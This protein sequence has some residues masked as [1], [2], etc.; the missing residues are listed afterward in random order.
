MG[1]VL[2]PR[3]NSVDIATRPELNDEA[4]VN[5]ILGEDEY[6]LKE[7][8]TLSGFMLDIGAHVGSVGLA[9]AV[10]HPALTVVMVEPVPDN[11]RLIRESIS[12]NHLDGRVHL[13]EAAAGAAGQRTAVCR[14]GYH[15]FQ[16]FEDPRYVQQMSMIGNIW[17]LTDPSVVEHEAIEVPVV[18]IDSLAERF[19]V[20]SFAFTK[21]DCEGCEWDFLKGSLARLSL[22]IGEW[23]D[24]E[25]SAV[26]E[27]LGATHDCE[28]IVDYGGSGI[29]RA[30]SRH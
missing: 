15:D 21:I 11:A 19:G 30:T 6:R 18:T 9:M 3:G 20:E 4:L 7:L 1:H 12:R 24:A 23:H 22:I 10:D 26:T 8:P 5:G 28:L 14:Y 27:R 25:F 13:V 2:T 29:F 16:G 17:R